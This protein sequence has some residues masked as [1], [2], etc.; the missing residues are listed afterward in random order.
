[1]TRCCREL[2]IGQAAVTDVDVRINEWML[3]SSSRPV[4]RNKWQ[5]FDKTSVL[6]ADIACAYGKRNLFS[7]DFF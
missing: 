2:C 5:D 6:G 4:L 1:M 3:E 7:P